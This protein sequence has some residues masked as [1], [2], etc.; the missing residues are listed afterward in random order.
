M[1]TYEYLCDCGNRFEVIRKMKDMRRE[2]YCPL[3]ND[4]GLLMVSKGYTHGDEA[5]WLNEEQVRGTLLD[6]SQYKRN[7]T[8][9]RSEY[10]KVMKEKGVVERG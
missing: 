9:T 5:A 2:E 3:C 7:E 8:F 10:K 1:P 4:L 6:D